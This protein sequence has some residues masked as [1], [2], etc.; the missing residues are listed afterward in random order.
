MNHLRT[1]H[2]LVCMQAG[3]YQNGTWIV[4]AAKAGREDGVDMMGQSCVIAPSGEVVALSSTL[5][6]ELV[7]H[8]ADLDLA[9]VYKRFFDFPNNRRPACYRAIAAEPGGGERAG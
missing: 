6:D 1:F 4:A 7:C 3:A 9:A 8:D 2:H 5:G